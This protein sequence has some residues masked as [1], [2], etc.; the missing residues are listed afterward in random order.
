MDR[1]Q[2]LN[3]PETVHRYALDGLQSRLWTSFPAIVQSVNLAA[4][5]I[6]AQPVIQGIVTN[7]DGST[8]YVNLPLLLDVP[9]CFPSAGGFILTFPI[10]QGDEVLISI[11]SRCIDAWWQQGGIQPPV[12]SRMHDLSD[13]FAIPGPRSQPNVV[14]AISAANVQL[15]NDAGTVYLEITPGGQIKLVAPSGVVVTGNLSVSGSVT[16]QSVSTIAGISLATH[17]HAVSTAP[18]T[19]GPAQP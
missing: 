19:T 10:A 2:L 11:A 8:T 3:D 9:L 12:E 4:M 15:R 5:T 14:N 7:P 17:T 18:G 6:E 1:R 16:G 13:G